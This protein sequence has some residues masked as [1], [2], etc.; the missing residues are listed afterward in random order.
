[1]LESMNML[2]S[3]LNSECCYVRI[4]RI[5]K[6]RKIS[7]DS[8]SR[9]VRKFAILA[10]NFGATVYVDLIDLQASHVTSLPVFKEI[11]S[12]ELRK[13]IKTVCQRITGTLLNFLHI[14]K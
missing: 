14:H 12:Q 13:M 3:T 4:R 9:Y 2:L 5:I 7:P 11:R 10:V 1:M 8:R 6:A